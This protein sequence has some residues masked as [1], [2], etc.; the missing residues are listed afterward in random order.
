MKYSDAGVDIDK[1]E[2][3]MKSIKGMVKDTFTPNVMADFGN[4]G[5]LFTLDNL[6]IKEPVLVSSV[7]GVGTKI[8]VSID[9]GRFSSVGEDI[10]N[11]CTDD[12][13]VQGARPLF[14]LDYYATGVLEEE[15][16]VG[17]IRGIT[18]ACKENQCALLGGETAEMPGFYQKGDF[19]LAGTIVGIAEKDQIIDGTKIKAG[20]TILGLPSSGL[21]T[22][23]YSLARK[24]L[25]EKE[26][27]D[28]TH[29]PKG[30]QVSIGD[31]LTAPH[32]S[33]LNPLYPL[34]QKKQINGMVH[35]TGGGFPGN[36]PRVLPENVG[37]TIRTD[38]WETPDIFKLIQSCGQVDFDEMH[39]TFNM[40]L[41]ML[42]I[43]S[44][45]NLEAVQAELKSK[46]ETF[47][48]V[49]EVI[50]RKGDHQV[51]LIQ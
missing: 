8:K 37:V 22:N 34:V 38:A 33:Y 16:L 31:A 17:V 19:D 40:G 42:L 46:N 36:I 2:K 48:H 15:A 29:T 30:H 26:G 43:I 9:M 11:H 24:V 10:V 32:R 51:T 39:K 45:E 3:A 44:P 41:G 4:F 14:F 20:D 7:D 25:F 47:Y 6:G 5:G 49:G 18:K 13:L 35:I 28:F 27:F 23:G 1:A 21:H 50:E 12:I